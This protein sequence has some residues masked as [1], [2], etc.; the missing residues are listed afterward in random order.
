MRKTLP[1]KPRTR[2]QDPLLNTLEAA[3]IAGVT[4]E[5]VARWAAAGRL[6][7]KRISGSRGGRIRVR[8]SDLRALLRTAELDSGEPTM[9]RHGR[10]VVD[11]DLGRPGKYGYRHI[12]RSAAPVPRRTVHRG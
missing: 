7:S 12:A 10:A 6:P 1:S 2:R 9:T 4:R 11:L 8:E 5:T 3:E